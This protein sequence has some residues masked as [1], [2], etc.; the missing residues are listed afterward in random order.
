MAFPRHPFHFIYF[1]LLNRNILRMIAPKCKMNISEVFLFVPFIQFHF[2]HQTPSLFFT[3]LSLWIFLGEGALF[4]QSQSTCL[5]Q[6]SGSIICYTSHYSPCNR[7][8]RLLNISH[9]QAPNPPGWMDK[10]F[11]GRVSS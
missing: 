11:A 7:S 9:H 3:F 8:L 10:L 1:L 6:A 4:L 5:T 2:Y